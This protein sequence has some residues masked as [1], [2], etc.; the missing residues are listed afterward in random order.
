MEFGESAHTLSICRVIIGKIERTKSLEMIGG[1]LMSTATL[2]L[3][4]TSHARSGHVLSAPSKIAE[5]P[6]LGSRYVEIIMGQNVRLETGRLTATNLT[7][8][9]CMNTTL[10][11][12]LTM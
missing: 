3:T 10:Y 4:R 9:P 7:A 11:D 1:L 8:S 5:S 6:S 2:E 12:E